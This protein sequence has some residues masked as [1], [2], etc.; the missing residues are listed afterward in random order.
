MRTMRI[1]KGEGQ[2]VTP[3]EIRT[4]EASPEESKWPCFWC[5]SMQAHATGWPGGMSTV[6][7]CEQH[8]AEYPYEKRLRPGEAP[9]REPGV[10]L[11]HELKTW[12]APFEAIERGTKHHEIRK[13]DRRFIQGDLLQLREWEPSTER[14]TGRE[15][16]VRV[17]Y[18]SY[19]GAWGLPEDMCVMS[20][21]LRRERDQTCMPPTTSNSCPKVGS[22]QHGADGGPSTA[23]PAPTS[24]SS[25]A[26][27]A[28]PTPRR[29]KL[30]TPDNP[31]PFCSV[32]QGAGPS[33]SPAEERD[34]LRNHLVTAFGPVQEY[35]LDAILKDFGRRPT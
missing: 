19:G 13:N 2:S 12:P 29:C 11:L 34:L 31:S 27:N 18:V 35:I 5:G 25:T 32:C 4:S 3:K 17:S 28:S 8:A 30:H 20:I 15:R 26:P 16:T 24:S 6:P 21:E 10:T 1:R 22:T 33:S 7:A 14:Y 9:A 23:Y